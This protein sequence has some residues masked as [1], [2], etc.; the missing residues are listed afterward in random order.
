[1]N[2]FLVSVMPQVAFVHEFAHVWDYINGNQFSHGLPAFR[3]NEPGPT[4][5]GSGLGLGTWSTH[6]LLDEWAES[7]AA[8]VY[9][10]YIIYLR[11]PGNKDYKNE[12]AW[13]KTLNLPSYYIRPGLGQLHRAYVALQIEG[14]FWPYIR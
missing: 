3:G 6:P 4:A 9:P 11:T 14:P 10:E 5:Y 2:D 13:Q 8:Y 1:M 12:Q 7:V